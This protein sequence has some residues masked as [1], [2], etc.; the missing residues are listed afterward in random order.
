MTSRRRFVAQASAAALYAATNRSVAHA[1]PL[2]LPLAIQ[3]YSVRQQL[4]QDFQGTLQQVANAGF[5]E[6]ESAGYFGKSAAEVKQALQKSGLHCVSSHH[7]HADLRQKFD[8]LLAFDKEIGVSYFICSSPTFREPLPAG[9]PADSRAMTL[10]DWRWNAEQFNKMAEKT[11]ALGIRFGYHN[12]VHEFEPINGT[13]PYMELLRIMDPAKTTLELDCGWA[14]VAGIKPQ[15]LMRDHP[16]RFSMLHIKDFKDPAAGLK[17]AK[18][19]ELGKGDID[20][21][22]IFQQAAKTQKIRHAF[23]EQEAFDMPWLDSLKVDADYI[24]GLNV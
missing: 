19:T 4:P 17:G 14:M 23:V 6:V 18:V 9:A 20:Y 10:D 13:V 7:S 24:R 11:A 1:T 5:R 8:E 3:L 22:P 21:R 16:N 15:D 12:H 2:G